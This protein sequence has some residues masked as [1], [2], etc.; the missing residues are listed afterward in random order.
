MFFLSIHFIS[1]INSFSEFTNAKTDGMF[2]KLYLLILFFVISQAVNATHIIGGFMN[3]T[4]IGNNQYDIH[5]VVYRDCINGV[6]PFDDPATIAVYDAAGILVTAVNMIP[7]SA[8]VFV[9]GTCIPG[10][11]CIRKANY[12]T[13]LTM[14][15]SGGPFTL[16]YQR[17]CRSASLINLVTP[18]DYGM[19]F[20]AT[21][22]PNIPNSSPEYNHSFPAF[23][24]VGDN[25]S[26]DGSATDADGDVLVYS[27]DDAHEGASLQNPLPNTSLPPY[28]PPYNPLVWSAGFSISDMLGGPVPLSIDGST[29]Q[30]SA[31]P[32]SVGVFVV[33]Q[34][35][36][37]YRNGNLI[38]TARREFVIAVNP[39][40][41][42]DG[43]GMVYADNGTQPLDIGKSWL[44]RKNLLDSILTATDTNAVVNGNYLHSQ[45]I[46]GI[47]L[48]K[49]SADS[50]SPF[51]ATNI[52]TYYGNELFWYDATEIDFCSGNVSSID[53][54]LIQGVNPG[55]PGFIGGLISQ[56]ANRSSSVPG[57][58]EGI[59]II[60]FDLLS[61]PV[62]YAI[63]DANGNFGIGNLS[64]GTYKV[65]V[66]RLN[67]IVD[68]SV[69]PVITLTSADPVQNNLSFML[70]N[71]WL[72]H[73]GFVGISNQETIKPFFI[74]PNPVIAELFFANSDQ[75]LYGRNYTISNVMGEPLQTGIISGKSIL[76]ENLLPQ[77]YVIKID[78]LKGS[79]YSKFIKW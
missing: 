50:I 65:Y 72:E 49:G 11:V 74:Y 77:V 8:D 59:T 60:L 20:Y 78:A 79:I 53:I 58:L 6:P 67:Y 75:S 18:E 34:K 35:I 39:G 71:T 24:Y 57:S 23:T 47:Y 48:I 15:A 25:L 3:Y 70:H 37:E 26:F 61:N 52:P 22:D 51:Y 76:V 66:D 45:S 17:C 55:G 63:T 68:N 42:A 38:N 64:I 32:G 7:D 46:N 43:S 12:Y 41:Y 54:N 9:Q 10:N 36:E 16:A 62:A 30:M 21:I 4:G 40:T 28:P 33:S 1:L 29:G 69:A 73:N 19:T 5:L 31:V 2:K 13:T 56:G 44:I 14:P 27:L